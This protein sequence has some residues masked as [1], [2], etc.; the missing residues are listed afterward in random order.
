MR[1]P[2]DQRSWVSRALDATLKNNPRREVTFLVAGSGLGKSVACYRTLVAHVEAGGFG[3]VLTHSA[4]ATAVTLDQAIVTA[5]SQLHPAL[6]AVPGRTRWPFCSQQRELLFLVVEDINRSGQ[7]QSLLE[8]IIGWSVDGGDGKHSRSH[9]RLVC[10]IWPGTIALLRG[11]T[12]KLIEPM[13]IVAGGFGD[14]EGREA[15]LARARLD[16][17]VLSTLRAQ[18]ISRALGN[19]PL[20]IALHDLQTIPDP[21]EV[22][23]QFIGSSLTRTAAEEREPPATAYHRLAALAKSL[24]RRQIEVSWCDVSDWKGVQGEPLRLLGRIAHRGEIISAEGPSSNQVLRFRHDRVR[25]CLL[26]D[27]ATDLEGQNALPEPVITDPYFA[28]LLGEVLVQTQVKPSFL[29]NT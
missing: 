2:G 4:I 3:L 11:E 18:E 13:L 5:L 22:I 10:P 7:A 17:R 19:D 6:A 27:A 23:G 8:R 16:G 26:V 1:P 9:W 25:D 12:R 24:A 20:L 28:E 21:R 15:V 29:S 14:T